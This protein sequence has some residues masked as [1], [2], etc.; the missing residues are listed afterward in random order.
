[1]LHVHDIVYFV[2]FCRCVCGS[3][4]RP[5]ATGGAAALPATALSPPRPS[6][7]GAEAEAAGIGAGPRDQE[8][9]H[10]ELL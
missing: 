5:P 10:E 9:R 7:G 4:G 3:G 6:A 2:L 1:M 8:E